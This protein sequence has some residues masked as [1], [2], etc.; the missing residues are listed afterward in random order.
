MLVHRR[1]TPAFSPVPIYTMYTWVE[2]GTVRVKCLAQEHNTMSL[3][4]TRT[5]TTQS[6]VKHSNHEATG[7]HTMG[8]DVCNGPWVIT[9]ELSTGLCFPQIQIGMWKMKT[10]NEDPPKSEISNCNLF[11]CFQWTLHVLKSSPWVSLQFA[12]EM[13][14]KSVFQIMNMCSAKS[15]SVI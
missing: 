7:P 5:Q 2:R 1:V 15:T 13:K 3:A 6:G 8:G 14:G 10:K 12:N 9:G 4:R 11:H